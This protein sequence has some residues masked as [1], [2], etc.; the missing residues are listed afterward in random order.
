MNWGQVPLAYLAHTQRREGGGGEE[1]GRE[2]V[3]LVEATHDFPGNEM[4]ELQLEKGDIVKLARQL[5][6][7]KYLYTWL[8]MYSDLAYNL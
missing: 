1:E 6:G 8:C 5:S 2:G 7:M 3:R 4:G